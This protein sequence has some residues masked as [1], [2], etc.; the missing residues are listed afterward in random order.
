MDQQTGQS[1]LRLRQ[2]SLSHDAVRLAAPAGRAPV[3]PQDS[4]GQQRWVPG[5]QGVPLGQSGPRPRGALTVSLTINGGFPTRRT[6]PSSLQTPC[7]GFW[8]T[9]LPLF[10]LSNARI[11]N[12]VMRQSPPTLQVRQLLCACE[13]RFRQYRRLPCNKRAIASVQGI[14]NA[15][16]EGCGL[17]PV[18][19]VPGIS[20]SQT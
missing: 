12:G 16:C 1:P 17:F 8:A 11:R 9:S 10:R 6:D 3:R 4:W 2:L 20:G 18:D 15:H 19:L 7:L 13:G 14:R 5:H